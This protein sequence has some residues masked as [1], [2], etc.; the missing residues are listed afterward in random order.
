MRQ[1]NVKKGAN[2]H[3]AELLEVVEDKHRKLQ[4]AENERAQRVPVTALAVF[5]KIVKVQMLKMTYQTIFHN[6]IE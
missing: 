6:I 4:K 5:T 2:D 1:A 3:W